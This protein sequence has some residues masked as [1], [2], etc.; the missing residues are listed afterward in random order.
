MITKYTNKPNPFQD[1]L[2]QIVYMRQK[3]ASGAAFDRE[4]HAKFEKMTD[5]P[6]WEHFYG[7]NDFKIPNFEIKWGG[8]V[9]FKG[10]LGKPLSE[11]LWKDL[12]MRL[13]IETLHIYRHN[14]AVPCVATAY[15]NCQIYLDEDGNVSDIYYTPHWR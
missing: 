9:S 8:G 10:H 2:D 13:Q 15:G 11:R 14:D 7:Y 1:I 4:E 6:R 12:M 3:Q 5:T